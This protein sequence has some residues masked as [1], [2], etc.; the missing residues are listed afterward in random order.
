LRFDAE[1]DASSGTQKAKDGHRE[2]S[3]KSGLRQPP[4]AYAAIYEAENSW[5]P[6]RASASARHAVNNSGAE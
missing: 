3:E 1:S 5:P 2:F 4:A 6:D